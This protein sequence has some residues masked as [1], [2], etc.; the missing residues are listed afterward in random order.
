MS[1]DILR[2]SIENVKK[3]LRESIVRIENVYGK[4]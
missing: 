1:M 3:G 4:D 2:G